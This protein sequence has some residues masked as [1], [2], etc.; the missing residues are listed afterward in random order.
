MKLKYLNGIVSP[1]DEIACAGA[2]CFSPN[3]RKLAVCT[4]DR[5]V[6]LFDDKFRRRDKFATKPVDS[7]YG[8]TGY[9]IKSAS[10][11]P[12]SNKLAIGQTDDIVFV[13]KLGENWDEKKVICNKFAQSSSC[14]A[15][16]WP[17]ESKLIIGLLDGK[18]R[19]A[20]TNS[21]KCSTLYKAA[22]GASVCA[23]AQHPNKRSFLSGHEDGSM[24]LYSFD[25][26]SHTRV[27]VHTCAPYA[28]ILSQ[29]GILAAGSDR[30]LVSYTEGG[31][32]LQQFDY[33]REPYLEKE[34]SV[35]TLDTSGLNAVFGT[36]DRLHL[37]SWS[38]R[39]GAW[40][41]GGVLNIRN[42]YTIKSLAW[43]YDGS[44]L[45]CSNML[46]AVIA[47]DCSM[48]KTLLKNRFELT[49]VSPSQAILK[50]LQLPSENNDEDNDKKEE[51]NIKLKQRNDTNDSGI[52]LRSKIGA[53]LGEVRIMGR[54]QRYAIVYTPSTLI[55]ADIRTGLSSEISWQSGGNEKFYLD[56]ENVAFIVNAGEI[57]FVEY[58]QDELA[59]WIRT[60]RANPHQISVRIRR[61][62]QN[63]KELV[64]DVR[65]VA[66]LLD[67]RTISIIDMAK[68][69]QIGHIQH[70]IAIDWLELNE[71]ATKLLFRDIRS[72]LH[73]FSLETKQ[74]VHLIGHC[75]YVQWVP[76]SDVVVAQSNSQLCV[77]YNTDENTDRVNQFPIL[78]D[79][80]MVARD[81]SRTEVI[82][83]ENNTR[84]AY[85]LDS[86]MIEFSSALDELD[87]GRAVLFLER[88]EQRGIGVQALWR[89]LADVALEH[90][91][92]FVAQ[93]CFASLNDLV[94]VQFLQETLL[95]A[96][97]QFGIPLDSQALSEHFEVQSRLA[98]MTKQ[99]KRAERILLENNAITEAIDMWKRIGDWESA[100]QLAKAMNY[101]EIDPLQSQ[102]EQYLNETGQKDK[103]AELKMRDGDSRAALE[104]F[105]RAN[106][107]SKAVQL[108]LD[109]LQ[110]LSQ[111]KTSELGNDEEDEEEEN[112]GIIGQIIQSLQQ[113]EIFDKLGDLYEALDKPEK[114]MDAYNNGNFYGKAIQIARIHFPEGVIQLEENW[115]DW[116]YS[117][118]NYHLAATHF[119]ESGNTL[120]AIDASILAKEWDKALD[121]LK[122]IESTPET[123][124]FYEKIAHNFELTGELEKAESLYTLS[125]K[126]AEAVEMYNKAGNWARAFKLA[127]DFFGLEE[128]RQLYNDKAAQLAEQRRF[129]DAEE[130][131]V[132]LGA[133]DQA[134]AMYKQ[135]DR[136]DDMMRLMSIYYSG[137]VTTAQRRLAEELEQKGDLRA[138]EEQYMLA[139]DWA[140]AIDMYQQAGQ[141]AD[142]H[143]LAKAS[144]GERAHKQI[145]Y[146][147]A[148]SLG[149]DAAVKLL[150]RHELLDEAINISVTKSDFD[151]AFELCRL[152]AGH[153]LQ[154]V[155]QKYAEHLEDEGE[156]DKAEEQYLLAGKARE[157]VIMRMHNRNWE[158]AE[159]IA[160]EQ[161]PEELPELFVQRARDAIEHRD[162]A[163][164]ESYLLRANR[165]DIILAFYRESAI[166]QEALRIARDYLP[167]ELQKCQSDYEEYQ[168]LSGAKGAHS[169]IAQ[170]KEWERQ[171]EYRRAVD[172]WMRVDGLTQDQQ[173]VSQSL[174]KAAEL[175]VKF[176]ADSDEESMDLLTQVGQRQM[177]LRQF[178]A[179]GETFLLADKPVDSIKALL[180]GH[181]WAKAKRVAEQLAP[182]L[183]QHVDETYREFLRTN[184]RIGELIDVDVVSAIDMLVQ[185][186]NWEKALNTAKQQ[187]HRPLLDKYLA[188]YSTELLANEQFEQTLDIFRKYGASFNQQLLPIYDTL[189]NKLLNARSNVNNY[190]T[191]AT[192]RDLLLEIFQQM[193]EQN[194]ST[195]ATDE[196][197]AQSIQHFERCLFATHFVAFQKAL[198]LVV[199]Q[200]E[201]KQKST[202]HQ[203]M[204]ASLSTINEELNMLRLRLGITILRYIEPIRADKAFYDAGSAC[205]FWGGTDY[206]NMTFL[207]FNHLLD[208]LDAIDEDDPNLVD[209][210]LF[211]GT[212][213]PTS[214]AL[215]M[216]KYLSVS[217]QEEVKEWVL[218][219]SVGRQNIEKQLKLDEGRES[220][221][222][223]SIDSLGND[224]PI[225]VISGYPVLDEG[226]QLGGGRVATHQAWATFTALAKQNPTD[227]L[228]DIQQFLAKW[229]GVSN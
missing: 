47:I 108:L 32:L 213:I 191:I 156:L 34:F 104:L 77:W 159:R 224:Y 170:A 63:S 30:R 38:Q 196:V 58:G 101:S 166:W 7:K 29:V 149:G 2:L 28:L 117:Q 33:S 13:Y 27:C 26:R 139:G 31:R 118:G 201:Q 80:E 6:L 90:S 146:L 88:S 65:R 20:S 92:L 190:E 174:A 8:K 99:F 17:S 161:C 96:E 212:D 59:G 44:I 1:L 215:P 152:G 227:E 95:R 177:A 140:A 21:N 150:L 172:C 55:L 73:L 154:F 16:I 53:E 137:E 142:A 120:R 72:A 222:A 144:G 124:P 206:E 223:S 45:A 179:A 116:L 207:L 60:E 114:A 188:A 147:W 57:N 217:E 189:V 81:A 129:N 86:A 70:N 79:V 160:Q 171:S 109:N 151:F 43:K 153:R 37:M 119:L 138:A 214:Y 39:R 102:Y 145:S 106:Q 199:E 186:G 54:E 25:S 61:S 225:C 94:R 42:L 51:E 14:V 181:E 105:L 103:A 187:K 125:G 48:K 71:R 195:T 183:E 91:H 75:S 115:G 200:Q 35:A 76:Q 193:T 205:K 228:F 148:K 12:D 210:G 130:L 131:Y 89:K 23:I 121:M 84:V 52:V 127:A 22:D 41:E 15:L 184:G 173:I 113:Q 157:A 178:L 197:T 162:F 74:T 40:D 36:F 56:N 128:S 67:V 50:D 169:L 158:A 111:L 209:N 11:S 18:V 110:L 168:L 180:E 182:E 194:D 135:A 204:D 134:I 4:M 136:T 62:K 192:L 126:F 163:V 219:I 123:T 24:F 49:F 98:M 143:R 83:M 112:N 221:E 155:Q 68:N 10:F 164:A 226:H 85:E 198:D 229:A 208:I 93:R 132:A 97:S 107:P 220:Y 3:G 211:E 175:I 185:S 122:S 87:L 100:I 176:L 165:P 133:P 218:A 64:E 66:Y 202:T 141:W 9:L 78:G 167:D 203:T 5:H 46:G 82:V 19:Q 216:N 69:N